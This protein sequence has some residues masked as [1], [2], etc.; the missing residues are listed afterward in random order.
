ML[1][2]IREL[3]KRRLRNTCNRIL[4]RASAITKS[5]HGVGYLI[6]F[7]NKKPPLTH[8]SQAINTEA[9]SE[10]RI[11]TQKWEELVA[12]G[13]AIQVKDYNLGFYNHSFV[14]PKKQRGEWR[15]INDLRNLNTFVKKF[16]SKLPG[17]QT[18][19]DSLSHNDWM[20]TIDVKNGYYN[21]PIHPDHHKY[22]R[23]KVEGKVYQMT[24]LPMGFVIS[25]TAFRAYMQPFILTLKEHF[26]TTNFFAYV[27]DILIN[28]PHM[29]QSKAKRN[30]EAIQF[31]LQV[32]GLPLKTVKSTFL[33]SKEVEY[34]GFILSSAKMSI[35]I[36]K[37]KLKSVRK[38]VLRT[39]RLHSNGTL[40]LKHLGTTIGQLIALL[41]EI[42]EARLHTGFLY[43]A[44]KATI[45][46]R[47]TWK[48]SQPAILNLEARAELQWWATFLQTQR[49]RKM[50]IAWRGEEITVTATDP[51]QHTIAGVFLKYDLPY[52]SHYLS[53]K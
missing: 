12:L 38:Q 42:K 2:S 23:F 29:R 10:G 11:L 32:L 52:F 40:K 26:P 46:A 8:R 44:Q 18:A 22:F 16:N 45:Q 53:R 1:F 48:A 21:C 4:E 49:F 41:P 30:L 9:R 20:T 31:A 34:Q 35:T 37:K 36:P 15:L 47:G 33:A 5:I 13:H 43:A 14:I 7:K 17:L 3:E 24:G 51:S 6:P 50:S 25:A 19:I 28:F 39:L 27:D